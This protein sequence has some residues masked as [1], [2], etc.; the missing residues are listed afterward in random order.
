MIHGARIVVLRDF[1]LCMSMAVKGCDQKLVVLIKRSA[2]E[3]AEVASNSVLHQQLGLLIVCFVL[4]S[5]GIV[6]FASD[7][8]LSFLCVT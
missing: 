4:S 6:D 3:S 5:K 1:M 2:E 7:I 8:P